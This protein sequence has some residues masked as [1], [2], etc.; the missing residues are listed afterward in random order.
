VRT[1]F[2]GT[3][4][5]LVDQQPKAALRALGTWWTVYLL[6]FPYHPVRQ[7]IYLPRHR[8]SFNIAGVRFNPESFDFSDDFTLS[9]ADENARCAFIRVP[10]VHYHVTPS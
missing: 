4:V 8:S 6:R 1:Q 2:F 7:R 9:A 3:T 5:T 10:M